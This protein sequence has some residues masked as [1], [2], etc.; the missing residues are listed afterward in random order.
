METCR[1][2]GIAIEYGNGVWWQVGTCGS[3][4]PRR[5]GW[6]MHEPTPVPDLTDRTAVEQWLEV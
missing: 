5:E 6:Y 1:F 4:C 2:C 3:Q